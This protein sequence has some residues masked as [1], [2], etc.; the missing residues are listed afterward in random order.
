MLFGQIALLAWLTAIAL[1]ALICIV[2]GRWSF[3]LVIA[4]V[5]ISL[6]IITMFGLLYALPRRAGDQLGLGFIAFH[7][8][9]I[10]AMI[11]S[12]GAPVAAL[13][14]RKRGRVRPAPDPVAPWID[15]M[16]ENLEQKRPPA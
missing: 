7:Y 9:M 11:V 14:V 3:A 8:A 10:V 16:R 2:K 5:S 13:F 12:V 6:P 1:A 15:E 4:G